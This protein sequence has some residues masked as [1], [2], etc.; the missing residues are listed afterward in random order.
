MVNGSRSQF[1][2]S[3]PTTAQFV[4]EVAIT[5]LGIDRAKAVEYAKAGIPEYWIVQPD[6]ALTEVFRDPQNGQYTSRS[7]VP[8][9]TRL[10]SS[11]LPGFSLHLTKALEEE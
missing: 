1:R 11:A 10:E 6:A 7:D 5:S 3:K 2:R 4:I 9:A 8:A